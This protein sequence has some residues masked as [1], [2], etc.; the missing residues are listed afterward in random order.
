[1]RGNFVYNNKFIIRRM[2]SL[3]MATALCSSLIL[4]A[5]SRMAQTGSIYRYSGDRISVINTTLSLTSG[6]DIPREFEDSMSALGGELSESETGIGAKSVYY[7]SPQDALDGITKVDIDFYGNLMSKPVDVV[8]LMDQSGSMNMA[9][10]VPTE[11]H[12][13][14][15]CL[16]PEHYYRLPMVATV[17]GDTN[18]YAYYFQENSIAPSKAWYDSTFYNAVE[19]RF[20]QDMQVY[21]GSDAVI[22]NAGFHPEFSVYNFPAR[23]SHYTKTNAE[24]P[25]FVITDNIYAIGTGFDYRLP[26]EQAIFDYKTVRTPEEAGSTSAAPFYSPID[27]GIERWVSFPRSEGFPYDICMDRMAISKSIFYVLGSDILADGPLN[28]AAFVNFAGSIVNERELSGDPLS[29]EFAST[30]G[31][32]DTNYQL[33]FERAAE[34]FENSSDTESSRY[35]IMVTDGTPS[36]GNGSSA[37]TLPSLTSYVRDVLEGTHGAKVYYIGISLSADELAVYDELASTVNGE[38]LAFSSRTVDDLI[39]M[40]SILYN[41]MTAALEVTDSLGEQFNINIDASHPIEVMWKDKSGVT[42]TETATS[43]EDA[44]RFGISYTGS[45][46]N[47]TISW[48][49]TSVDM[50]GGRLSFYQKLNSDSIVMEDGVYPT[51]STNKGANVS[52]VDYNGKNQS[53]TLENAANIDVNGTSD[54]TVELASTTAT[55]VEYGDIIDYTIKVTNTPTYGDGAASG[56][57]LLNA[58]V[59]ENTRFI[60][61]NGFTQN[62]SELSY[63]LG[64]LAAGS[65]RTINYSVMT[66]ADG[67]TIDNSV[68]IAIEGID[69]TYGDDGEMLLSSGTVSHSV[70]LRPY[71]KVKYSANGGLDSG[72]NVLLE[73]SKTYREGDRVIVA[74]NTF[75]RTGYTFD[76]WSTNIEGTGTRYN[77]GD[78]FDMGSSD[79]TLFARWRTGSIVNPDP[80]PDPAPEPEPPP[81]TPPPH[82]TPNPTPS[83]Y[84]SPTPSACPPP[85]PIQIPSPSPTPIPIPSPKPQHPCPPSLQPLRA[86]A[87]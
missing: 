65:S 39:G 64:Y 56:D 4:T 21:Y 32:R 77:G 58:A 76:G 53:L 37:A 55:E 1:M 26:A 72:G 38:L 61:G 66:T 30:L 20:V 74:S 54:I 73:D 42:H 22:T 3:L 44:A 11:S 14:T 68:K 5:T 75:V 69:E 2:T 52:Y 48:D 41:V 81:P 47:Y 31:Y 57:I 43:L 60:E 29:S 63:N 67:I 28:R 85:S 46:G 17:N 8:F 40:Y 78:T 12:V 62:G 45:D 80:D 25:E 23:Y 51:T 36:I 71:F 6:G 84:P 34:I 15:L 16:N 82:A 9:S 83:Q 87:S 13:T 50:A 27:L 86:A 7:D 24:N 49:T 18:N 35:V 19:T 10:L 79:I 70:A 59:P 33:A